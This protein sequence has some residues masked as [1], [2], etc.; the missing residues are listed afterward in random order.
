[1]CVAL[2]V[3]APAVQENH[4]CALTFA[5]LSKRG[6]NLFC[7]FTREEFFAAR[8]LLI[9]SILGTDMHHH[10]SLTQELLSHSS[11]F[12]PE[13]DGDRALLVGRAVSATCSWLMVFFCSG[14]CCGVLVARATAT[15]TAGTGTSRAWQPVASLL[16]A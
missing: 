11:A 8:K 4:H 6:S 9:D 5:I 7:R 15:G 3:C 16:C 2:L 12:T 14:G 13:S 1:M 10:F